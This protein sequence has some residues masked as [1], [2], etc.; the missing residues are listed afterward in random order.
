MRA[1]IVLIKVKA[2]SLI[3]ATYLKRENTLNNWD[4]DHNHPVL[5]KADRWTLMETGLFPFTANGN[6]L[7]PTDTAIN[8]TVFHYC[9]NDVGSGYLETPAMIYIRGTLTREWTSYFHPV[10]FM[11]LLTIYFDAN[12][13]GLGLGKERVEEMLQAQLLKLFEK[14][15]IIKTTF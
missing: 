4:I 9:V 8:G 10:F 13:W 3:C 6:P 11:E 12:S 1:V 2:D 15:F 7:I 5:T 14:L